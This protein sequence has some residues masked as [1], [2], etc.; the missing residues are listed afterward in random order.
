M[1]PS[2]ASG[3]SRYP[4]FSETRTEGWPTQWSCAR[5]MWTRCGRKGENGV[6]DVLNF[7]PES[8]RIQVQPAPPHTS[9][10]TPGKLQRYQ[11]HQR[12][13]SQ[14][15]VQDLRSVLPPGLPLQVVQELE[16]LPGPFLLG[17]FYVKSH[18]QSHPM[19][20]SSPRLGYR[21]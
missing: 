16:E 4:P 15:T 17:Y 19:C 20:T 21:T 13:V 10:H 2:C 1:T 8:C 11:R 7:C 18:L 14:A 3:C 9:L 5:R 6:Q 12:A